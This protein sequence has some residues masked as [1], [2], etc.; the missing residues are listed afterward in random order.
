MDKRIITIILT[1][2]M[3]ILTGGS[4]TY[5]LVKASETQS[6]LE[7]MLKWKNQQKKLEQIILLKEFNR[8]LL[9]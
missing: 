5:T 2:L 3:A 6:N 4:V 8:P 1:A 7:N 9:T